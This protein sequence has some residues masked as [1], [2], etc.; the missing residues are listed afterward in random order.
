LTDNYEKINFRLNLN[1]RINDRVS[2][3]VTLNPSRTEQRRFPIGVHDA[4]RQ[5]AWLPLYLDNTSINFVNRLRESNRW[6]DAQV[7]DYAMERM[8]DNYDLE[9]GMP[10]AS[11]GTGISGTS[12]QSSLA[13]VL[14][15]DRRKFQTKIFANTFVK[16]YKKYPLGRCTG[17]A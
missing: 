13:K 12:N 5:H 17:F 3:G 6:E 7:G 10:M 14:E 11:G 15:R 16:V 8:F 1:T 9:T 4:I 2:F